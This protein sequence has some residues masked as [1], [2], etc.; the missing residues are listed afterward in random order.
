MRTRQ[1]LPSPKMMAHILTFSTSQWMTVLT[2]ILSSLPLQ[3]WTWGLSSREDSH[4]PTNETQTQCKARAVKRGHS[5]RM[6]IFGFYPS[7][8]SGQ[9]GLW[10]SSTGAEANPSAREDWDTDTGKQNKRTTCLMK[11]TEVHLPFLQVQF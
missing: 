9:K 7:C 4:R 5:L 10:G 1:F 11:K 8:H 2:Q 3:P 6:S